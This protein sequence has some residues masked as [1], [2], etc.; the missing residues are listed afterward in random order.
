MKD[1][2]AETTTQTGEFVPLLAALEERDRLAEEAAELRAALAKKTALLVEV[3]AELAKKEH[4]L[5]GI[6]ASTSWRIT[7][8]IRWILD[9]ARGHRPG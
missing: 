8:P 3:S 1:E 5:A 2:T 6:R 7:A 9:R 4:E